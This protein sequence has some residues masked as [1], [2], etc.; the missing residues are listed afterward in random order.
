MKLV[1]VFLRLV[2]HEVGRQDTKRDR[3]ESFELIGSNGE[4]FYRVLHVSTLIFIC[5]GFC[6]IQ[7]TLVYCVLI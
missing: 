1:Q 6:F 5:T 3:F 7:Y 4:L 2:P